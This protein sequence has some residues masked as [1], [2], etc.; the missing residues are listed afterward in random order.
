MRARVLVVRAVARRRGQLSA[1][2]GSRRKD[3][4]I[5]NKQDSLEFLGARRREK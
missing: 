2:A 1:G 5:L 3:L 4:S